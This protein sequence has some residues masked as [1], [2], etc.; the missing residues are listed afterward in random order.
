MLLFMLGLAV[1]VMVTAAITACIKGSHE[2]DYE[3]LFH[4][5]A[6]SMDLS[7]RWTVYRYETE[8]GLKIDTKKVYVT[9]KKCKKCGHAFVTLGNGSDRDFHFDASFI[10]NK[11][12]MILKAEAQ[13][14]N[15]RLLREMDT[16]IVNDERVKEIMAP[17]EAAQKRLQTA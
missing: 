5:Q 4:R 11:V 9:Y 8:K 3:I 6:D 7:Y 2:H 13:A 12:E 15:D 17:L 16:R 1:G 10:A 14:E